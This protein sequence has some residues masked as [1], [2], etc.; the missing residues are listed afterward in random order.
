MR[1]CIL[2]DNFY[3]GSGI[4][5]VVQR[6]VRSSAFR[7]D[8]IYLAGCNRFIGRDAFVEA[9]SIVPA[10]RT[11]TFD[12]M[13]TGPRLITALFEFADWLREIHCDVVHVHHRRLAVLAELI[14]PLTKI[15][16]LFTG[17]LTFPDSA[18]FRRLSPHVVTGVSPSVVAYLRR[19]TRASQVHLVYNPHVFTHQAGRVKK[20]G[21]CKAISIGRLEPVKAHAVLIEA[22]A[23]LR[24]RGIDAHLDIHGEGPLRK[25]LEELIRVRRLQDRVTLPGFSTDLHDRMQAYSFNVL[26]SEREGFPNAVVEAAAQRLPTLL[27][28]VDGS[29]DTLPKALELPNGIPFGDAEE[30]ATSLAVWLRSP[31]PVVRDGE[32]FYES[33]S[34]LCELETI[35]SHYARIYRELIASSHVS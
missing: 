11:R 10:G 16:V 34:V 24:D 1:I 21:I 22:W 35:G 15:P 29:R 27:T 32:R 33:L 17:H 6:L 3:R 8:A 19:A 30:L 28:D 5:L 9:T 23:R 25:S 7:E 14:R 12:L 4:T 26:V 2:N 31:E 13:A 20:T 18:W